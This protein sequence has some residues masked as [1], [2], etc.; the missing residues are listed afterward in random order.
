MSVAVQ[1]VLYG[2]ISD[3]LFSRCQF[4]QTG[5]I[6]SDPSSKS[7]SRSQGSLKKPIPFALERFHDSLDELET[8]LVSEIVAN[9]TH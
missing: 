1:W 3:Q 6:F 7:S 2:A 5:R 9:F 4:M 8:E